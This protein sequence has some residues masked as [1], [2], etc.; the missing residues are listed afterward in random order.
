[1]VSALEYSYLA[2]DAYAGSSND[3]KELQNHLQLP[4][5]WE[6]YKLAV[7]YTPIDSDFYAVAYE[8]T[9]TNEIVIAYRGT[10]SI[11]ELVTDAAAS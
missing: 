1:M 2:L 7:P 6:E 5:T 8:N 10:D 3:N 4:G 9:E 11:T